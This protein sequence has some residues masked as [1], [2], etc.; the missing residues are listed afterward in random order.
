MKWMP[1]LIVAASMVAY[2]TAVA[3]MP[4]W[5]APDLPA[6]QPGERVEYPAADRCEPRYWEQP[7]AEYLA[8]GVEVQV[9]PFVDTLFP[10]YELLGLRIVVDL[11]AAHMTLPRG[12]WWIGIQPIGDWNQYDPFWQVFQGGL[13]DGGY[14]CVCY[15]GHFFGWESL[16]D[17]LG[18]DAGDMGMKVVADHAQV[19]VDTTAMTDHQT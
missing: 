15:T 14:P 12:V 5:V 6:T 3:Q 13:R 4:P 9:I 17:I 11:S 16:F 1:A 10:E 19:L 8:T 18:K 2:P 7:Y